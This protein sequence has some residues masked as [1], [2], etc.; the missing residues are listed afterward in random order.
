MDIDVSTL[1]DIVTHIH[2]HTKTKTKALPVQLMRLKKPLVFL[3]V[4]IHVFPWE[5]WKI[6]L[7][8]S[9]PEP[10]VNDSEIE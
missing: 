9:E 7:W 2:V 5:L 3:Y 1:I 10:L 6:R 4:H 8:K